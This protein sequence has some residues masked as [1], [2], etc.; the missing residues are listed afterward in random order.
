MMTGTPK[1]PFRMIAPNGA[2]IKK[3]IKHESATVNLLIVSI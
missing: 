1:P 3:N 2:P